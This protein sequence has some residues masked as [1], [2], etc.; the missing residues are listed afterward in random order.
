[1]SEAP[2]FTKDAQSGRRGRAGAHAEVTTDVT[3]VRDML[4]AA[5]GAAI[6]IGL[7]ALLAPAA[8]SPGPISRP[9]AEAGLSCESCHEAAAPHASE[10]SKPLE[11]RVR[12]LLS[13]QSGPTQLTSAL[14]SCPRC[15]G[16][17]HTSTRPA[18]AALAARGQLGCT[19]CHPAHGDAQGVTFLARGGPENGGFARWGSGDVLFGSAVQGPALATVPIV[20]LGA[21]SRCHDVR[22]AGDP[23]LACV[24]AKDGVSVEE[25]RPTLCFDEHQ[26]ARAPERRS[27]MGG[28]AAVCARQ[29]GPGRFAAWEAAEKVARSMPWLGGSQRRALA[30]PWAW[31]GAALAAASVMLA[32]QSGL[33]GVLRKRK[34]RAAPTAP[35]VAATRVRLPQINTATC[36]GCYACVDACPFDVLQI[37]RYIAVVARPADCCGVVLCQ[38]VCPNDSLRITEGEP[39]ETR[40]RVDPHLESLDAPGVFLAGDLTGLPLIK[41][42]IG[43]GAKAI[44]RVAATLPRA[45]RKSDDLDLAIIGAGPAGLSASLR[46]QELGL[47][48][49][50]LE[51]GSVAA[52]IR[53]FPRNKLV[54]DQ[55]LQLPVEGDLWL[56]ESTKEELLAQWMRIVRARHLDVRERHH[57][58]DVVREGDSFQVS[59]TKDDGST[60]TFRAARVLLAIGKRGTPRELTAKVA[61]VARSKVSY[62]LADARSFEGKRVLIV[63]LGDSAME[64]AIAITR[65]PGTEVTVSYRGEGFARGRPRNIAD[66][67]ALVDRRRLRIVFASQVTSV[68]ASTVT[69]ET[70][71]KT[72]TIPNDAVVVLIGGVPSWELLA[73]AG[74]RLGAHANP[75]APVD[76]GTRQITA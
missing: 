31:M 63:G 68:D 11:P 1:M 18:H 37:E 58:A 36:L 70:A 52:S 15:H 67:K 7:L 12:A 55:P 72:E 25:H 28:D 35:L 64:A 29:H 69:L 3:R 19:T 54:F 8:R 60:V 44:D 51:Q 76:P 22:N 41:N 40:P 6:G 50:T 24:I 61:G 5:L 14:G 42:A 71:S 33:R 57:V 30:P 17:A 13:R 45:P 32:V 47:R 34:K 27:A 39:I 65:Q 10:T 53:S 16:D 49:V 48:Y 59:C 38:Q 20:P 2:L 23:I 56:R 73:R 62:A 4:W 26:K 46:A 21:C 75:E 74:V 43:Q 66:I 9:H